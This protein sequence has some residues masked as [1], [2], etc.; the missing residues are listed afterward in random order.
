[1]GVQCS[2]TRTLQG[3]LQGVDVT[4]KGFSAFLDMRRCKDLG[5]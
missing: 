4:M 2:Q 5:S 3:F 1:M